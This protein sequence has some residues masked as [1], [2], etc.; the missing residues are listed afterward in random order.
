[1]K[2]KTLLIAYIT[3]KIFL[4]DNDKLRNQLSKLPQDLF[5][6]LIFSFISRYPANFVRYWHI[7]CNE[8]LVSLDLRNI[9]L[10]GQINQVGSKLLESVTICS[11]YLNHLNLSGCPIGDEDLITLSRNCPKLKSLYLRKCLPITNVSIQY[12]STGCR[13]L[14]KLDISYCWR[15]SDSGLFS[16]ALGIPKIEG[17]F[18]KGCMNITEDALISSF[19]HLKRL[20]EISLPSESTCSV[21]SALWSTNPNLEYLDTTQSISCLVKHLIPFKNLRVLKTHSILEMDKDYPTLTRLQNLHYLSIVTFCRDDSSNELRFVEALKGL[22]QL[23]HLNLKFSSLFSD[24]FQHLPKL[25]T[26]PPNSRTYSSSL[27]YSIITTHPT[28][29]FLDLENYP[30]PFI[31]AIQVLAKSCPFLVYLNIHSNNYLDSK[32]FKILLESCKYLRALDVGQ[33]RYGR[34]VDLTSCANILSEC[35]ELRFLNLPPKNSK[36]YWELTQ[37]LGIQCECSPT[38]TLWKQFCVYDRWWTENTSL[39]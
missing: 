4:F 13:K 16:I 25:T 23:C 33:Q 6:S 30:E 7:F 34:Y 32:S 29:T 17:L 11:L 15:I 2:L 9:P 22:T 1:M 14:K 39:I 10:F 31:N 5:D 24:I 8:G 18:L 26:L 19:S 37:I 35:E 36:Y 28:L 3:N 12:L 21:L 27:L 38:S 20:R